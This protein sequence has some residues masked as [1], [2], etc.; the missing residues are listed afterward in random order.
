ME[1][2][3]TT[4]F[5]VD[6]TELKKGIT[7][8]NKNIRLANAEF[9]A[10]TAGMDD[11]TKS[12][13]GISAKLKQL[14]SV[15]DAE[16]RKLESYQK[17]LEAVEK[18]EKENGKR[19]D[20]LRKKY[21]EAAAQFGE[22]SAEAKKYQTALNNVEKE[23]D[24]NRSAADKLRITIL[25][26]E[27]AVAKTQKEIRNYAD[28]LDNADKELSNYSDAA[29]DANKSTTDLSGGFT[30]TKGAL[31]SLVADGIK[32]AIGALKDLVTESDKAY[33]TL[34]AR[35]GMST[36]EIGKFQKQ[37]DELYAENYGE[38]IEDIADAM[39][40][41]VQSTKETDPSAIKELTKYAIV[42]RDTFGFDFTET[43]RAVNMLMDQFGVSGK[44]AYNLIVQGA[45][46]GLNKN[47]N[48]LDTI[49][50]YSVHYAN[51]GASAEEFF[52]S[53][54][55]GTESGTFEV[56]RLG[57]AYKEL[58]IQL[59]D[60]SDSVSEALSTLGYSTS[61]PDKAITET[62]E[63]I[64]ELE[65]KL[66][67]ATLEQQNFNDKTSELTRIKNADKIKEYSDE[68]KNARE[69]LTSLTTES[70]N[71]QKSV[72]DLQQQFAAGG[73]NAKQAVQEVVD[74]LFALDDE[75]QRNQVGVALF[76]TK[77]EDLGADA[78]KAL[79]DTNGTISETKGA[80]EELD[81][82]QMS[83]LSK[84]F[85]TLGR[86]VKS[87]AAAAF[88]EDLV[89]II[90]DFLD[91]L[92]KNG[93]IK[94]F[95]KALS[96]LAKTVLPPLSK[97]LGFVDENFDTIVG[98]TA[99]A[100]GLFKALKS[101]MAIKSI[102]SGFASAVSGL[103]GGI[104][105]ATGIQYAWNTALTANPIGLV[106]TAIGLLVGGI[107]ALSGA[108][109][110]QTADT[111]E[112]IESQNNYQAELEE[113]IQDYKDIKEESKEAADA[114]LA[115]MENVQ[116]LYG[117]LQ[118]LVD[119]NGKVKEADKA[120][121]DFILK[122]LNNALDTEYSMNGNIIEQYGTMKDEVYK[123]IE[124]KKADILLESYRPMYE[125]AIKNEMT[126]RQAMS[127]AY[128]QMVA[129]ERE[130]AE[131]QAREAVWLE[132]KKTQ[133]LSRE[134]KNQLKIMQDTIAGV[135][136]ALLV[137]DETTGGKGLVQIYNEA[138]AAVKECYSDI[139]KYE[140]AST[141]ILQGETAK[142]IELLNGQNQAFKTA[143]DTAN[144]SAEEQARILRQQVQDTANFAIQM[145][146]WYSSGVEGVTEDM[147]KTAEEQAKK[148]K[149][150]FEGIGGSIV[151]GI[152]EGAEENQPGLL[153]TF[154]GLW[155]DLADQVKKLFGI[156]SPSR[157]FRNEIGKMIPLG[158]AIG[159]ED[160]GK[161]V[162]SAIR[163]MTNNA[164]VA[165]RASVASINADLQSGIN[166]TGSGYNG[167]AGS[168]SFVI[169][170]YNTSPK[171]LNRLD[172]YRDTK[173]IFAAIKGV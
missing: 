37:I 87:E 36:A 17:Q 13:D 166:V 171:P 12:A 53:L 89:P 78:I 158:M 172:I 130:L 102:V 69:A 39:S 122:E 95:T 90:I 168:K 58:G 77:W 62:K 106:V 4:K 131:L 159:I 66:K 3:I 20:D 138:E 164:S 167:A 33:T 11:W 128:E 104:K 132:K 32:N 116:A 1:E 43:M 136:N 117:E 85:E 16:N 86:Q 18:A 14:Q 97:A 19:A 15:L 50:E 83:S 70:N 2:N 112:W 72:Q 142:A 23:Q 42:L 101:A 162:I 60:T 38:N 125:E 100:I 79:T 7:E 84:E 140:Q 150:E 151:D 156:H 24:S 21:E 52:N 108:M 29:K 55:N 49:N 135:E 157:W 134:E 40:A 137:G 57:D 99:T 118:T 147:V 161:S 121:A 149:E 148:A 169:N 71:S 75:V 74:R 59:K 129:K 105:I 27:A 143:D 65:T 123:L 48:L 46:Q 145:R 146:Q 47:N 96:N 173:R 28:E 152:G 98:V 124:A 160:E 45:Q 107:A 34:Q 44:E 111:D 127:T 165:A 91:E 6:L 103:S 5:K 88:E 82:V 30:V 153:A 120:R 64:E 126:L 94:D 63:K 170:Q 93:T 10:A 155:G 81:K 54:L 80:M 113:T 114:D 61:A 67:Y 92:E 8:A 22:T 163:E 31:S 144:E 115:Q 56:D 110:D 41:V 154:E 35:T 25:N 9:K 141:Y 76:G 73:D 68:L 119:Q 109:D 133:G 26:Q 51:M 139:G